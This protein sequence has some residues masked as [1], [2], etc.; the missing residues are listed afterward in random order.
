MFIQGGVSPRI[1]CCF[2]RGEGGVRWI[3]VFCWGLFLVNLLC[4]LANKFEYSKGRGPDPLLSPL[5]SFSK[6]SNFIYLFIYLFF[7]IFSKTCMYQSSW[8]GRYFSM[9]KMLRR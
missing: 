7:G 8:C 1:Y 3:I 4:Q 2:F 6:D 9:R 5:V